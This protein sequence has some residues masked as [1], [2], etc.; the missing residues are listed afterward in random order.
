MF[1]FVEC[2]QAIS[3]LFYCCL[4]KKDRLGYTFVDSMMFIIIIYIKFYNLIVWNLI[5]AFPL[6]NIIDLYNKYLKKN[7]GYP[8]INDDD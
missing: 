7:R 8:L 6:S 5:E 1:F 3:L 4:V 2:N